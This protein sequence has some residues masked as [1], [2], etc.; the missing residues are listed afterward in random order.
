MRRLIMVM[1]FAA[2]ASSASAQTMTC[3]PVSSNCQYQGCFIAFSG[4]GG[5]YGIGEAACALCDDA[6]EFAFFGYVRPYDRGQCSSTSAANSCLPCD[7]CIAALRSCPI[8][9]ERCIVRQEGDCDTSPIV[10]AIGGPLKLTG[11]PASFDIDADG[12]PDRISWTSA[13]TPLLALDRD[14]NG[15]IDSGAELFGTATPGSDGVNGYVALSKLD[16]N[17]DG[18]VS[19]DEAPSLLLWFDANSNAHSD[20]GELQSAWE[21]LD[22]VGTDFRE[23][24]RVDQY[25]NQFAWRGYAQLPSGKRVQTADVVFAHVQ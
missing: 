1:L 19:V 22:A 12:S 15:T 18:W 2:V 23:N 25:G 3:S 7:W 10:V 21:H 14:L 4:M 17:E 13:E 5:V 11:G 6:A 24:R 9:R 16:R 8:E 20:A